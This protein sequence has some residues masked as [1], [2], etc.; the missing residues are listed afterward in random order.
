V[1]LFKCFAQGRGP[2]RIVKQWM[3]FAQFIRYVVVVCDVLCH[4]RATRIFRGD[5]ALCLRTV[6]NFPH[7]VT[8]WRGAARRR[9]VVA[10]GGGGGGGPRGRRLPR[11]NFSR[12]A[13]GKPNE[14]AAKWARTSRWTLSFPRHDFRTLDGA[15]GTIREKERARAGEKRTGAHARSASRACA[16][17]CMNIAATTPDVG[18]LR[19]RPACVCVS[20]SPQAQFLRRAR[21][22]RCVPR[23]A[24]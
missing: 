13:P 16:R 11:F 8:G 18:A 21:P 5:D 7:A 22:V 3:A 17:R 9:L 2:R 24:S 23:H 20:A 12:S 6:R 14:R 19:G 4:H 15:T 1:T 10:G